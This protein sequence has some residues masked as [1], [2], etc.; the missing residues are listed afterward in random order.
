MKSGKA[1]ILNRSEMD[2]GTGRHSRLTV[3]LVV[4]STQV[5][6]WWAGAIDVALQRDVNL[7]C[8]PAGLVW[9][10]GLNKVLHRLLGAER[11]DGLVLAQWWPD[12]KTFQRYYKHLYSPLPTVN[13]QGF[14]AGCPGVMGDNYQGMREL[15]VH[16]IEAHGYRRVAFIQ[17]AEENPSA[18]GRYQAYC[19]VLAEYGIPLDEDLVTPGNLGSEA[20]QS[21]VSML[22]DQRGFTPGVDFEAVI[23]ANDVMAMAALQELQQRGVRVP[24]EVA[25]AGFDDTP[26]AALTTP[27]LTT[28]AMPNYE[29]GRRA[30]EMLLDLLAGNPVAEQELVPARLIVRQSCGC[31][32]QMAQPCGRMA[33]GSEKGAGPAAGHTLEKGWIDCREEVLSHVRDQVAEVVGAEHAWAGQDL[34]ALLFDALVTATSLPLLPAFYEI[35]RR[36]GESGA[37]LELLHEMLSI[38]RCWMLP[39]LAGE[40]E[41]LAR[42]EDL[43]HQA[44]V[45]LDECIRQETV[46]L[47]HALQE[48]Q[49]RLQE[50]GQAMLAA[51]D[52]PVLTGILVDRLPQWGIPSCYLALYEDPKAPGTSARLVLAYD[53]HGRIELP[54]EGVVFASRMLVPEGLFPEQAVTLVAEPLFWEQEQ[55]GFALFGVDKSMYAHS[56]R[57]GL[58]R[59]RQIYNVLRSHLSGALDKVLLLQERE[60]V[61]QALAQEKALLQAL[62]ENIPDHVYFKDKQSRFTRV[63]RSMADWIGH[64]DPTHFVGK[65]DFDFFTAEHASAA[66]EAEQEILRSGEP[67]VDLEERETWSDRPDTWVST[68]KMPLLDEN[69]HIVG[70]FGVSKN[71]TARKQ[72]EL[73]SERLLQDLARRN[74][75]LQTAAQVSQAASTI[76]DVDELMYQAVELVCERFGFY[77]VGLFLVDQEGRWATLRAG[78]G[79]PG[80]QMVE[81]GHRLQV[82]GQSMIG[83]C[84]ASGQS[85][86]AL[87]VEAERSHFRNPLLP[88]TRS[89][90]AL[91]LVSRGE[92]IGA[93]TIQSA[94]RRAF[95]EED[96]AALQTM[97]DQLATAISNAR[98]FQDAQMHAQELSILNE[99]SRTLPLVLDIEQIMMNTYHYTS[100]LMDTTN[101][102]IALYDA[103]NDQVSFPFYAEGER[104]GKARSRQAG[105]G[106]TEYV[107]RSRQPLLLARD[108][109][110]HLQSLGIESVGT[111]SLSWLGA[112]MMAGEQV[113]GVMAVQSYTTADVYDEHDRD[114]LS[115]VAGQAAIVIENARL[116][117]E[118][119]RR[120][121]RERIVRTAVD[122]IRQE[123]SEEGITRRA[124]QEIKEMLGATRSIMRLGTEEELLAGSGHASPLIVPSPE[125]GGISDQEQDLAC[126][127]AMAEA[128]WQKR[129]VMGTEGESSLLSLPVLLNDSV[130][131]VIGIDRRP[132]TSWNADEVADAEQVLGQVAQ[133]LEN[134]RLLDKEQQASETLA[135]QVKA[136]DCL[137]DI[138]RKEEGR[139]VLSAFLQW[140]TERVPV[141]LREADKCMVAIEFEGQVYGAEQARSA[142]CQIVQGLRIGGELV[143]RIYLA[144]LPDY[145][146][147]FGDKESS[148][149]GDISRRVSGYI[150]S[151]MLLEETR[152]NAQEAAVLYEL[153]QALS[154]QRQMNQVLD[155]IYN[156]VSRLLDATNFYIGLYNRERHELTFLL[157]VSESVIDRHIEVLS[158]DEGLS[159]YIVRTGEALLIEHDVGG[160]L[161]A[162]G[163]SSVGEPSQCWLGVPLLVGQEVLGVM[164]VQSYTKSYTYTE[165]DQR[166]L[167][168]IASQAA[169]AVQNAR[170]FEQLQAR[171]RREQ[172]LR[173]ITARVSGSLDPETIARIAVQELGSALGR[174]V[175]VRM[176]SREDLEAP[177][178]VSSAGEEGSMRQTDSRQAGNI[179]APEGGE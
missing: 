57:S 32:A 24:Y 16:L 71:I 144:Y 152:Q 33:G 54:P 109:D 27:A 111:S 174:R 162:N 37:N 140:V 129:P 50:T 75:Q 128:V 17:D 97:A 103:Q 53:E 38:F 35:V 104:I 167:V 106:M 117:E 84:I 150:E 72:I 31:L 68:T 60:Q 80:R 77:Y 42:G 131:G 30:T 168:A 159:G 52:L 51:I 90:M 65:T 94:T 119:H 15:L 164:A 25:V 137:N 122:R 102:Y 155:E 116:L 89:E 4:Q 3:G 66:Y 121:E 62:L 147:G 10:E 91:P 6:S 64:P 12:E 151:T 175:F 146:L 39:H 115:A 133:A 87:D 177:P 172:I 112:P 82:G 79:K 74:T 161:E 63:S 153:G 13:I 158:A 123:G 132:N 163:I 29:L 142:S 78:T 130:I 118:A 1:Q 96:V 154:A 100:R 136:L 166:R 108:V 145:G 81:Q 113:I 107:L 93:I 55:L 92:V 124:A 21:P 110:K 148:L 9:A 28:V 134:Q 22:I 34:A 8:F 135:D 7:I 179:R 125:K 86:I 11:I 178:L 43:W 2:A 14:Y 165:K 45:L 171:A 61:G 5:E 58:D 138:G 70:T 20:G 46:R 47:Q 173:Q 126:L 67:V 56:G 36:F 127:Q 83:Q 99:M 44:R 26:S 69:G 120:A 98:L 85:H 105:N 114:L 139:P 88:Q 19:E 49:A 41:V 48:E 156:G 143:G 59:Y 157:N 40:A 169:V 149:L 76:L 18:T 73:E 95:S 176:G 23:G 141:A 101:F 170:L 160:W